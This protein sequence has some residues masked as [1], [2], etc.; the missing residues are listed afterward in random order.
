[1]KRYDTIRCKR[2]V[3][4]CPRPFQRV[5]KARLVFTNDHS[6]PRACICVALAGR[7]FCS[8]D[9]RCRGATL[10]AG[11][12][13]TA[14]PCRCS[15]RPHRLQFLVLYVDDS[16]FFAPCRIPPPQQHVDPQN[17]TVGCICALSTEAIAAG[18]FLDGIH[19]APAEVNQHDA[20]WYTLGK[21]GSHNVVIAVLPRGKYGHVNAATVAR[22]M[23]H[24]FPNAKFGLMMGI[25][26]TLRPR[27]RMSDSVMLCKASAEKPSAMVSRHE[28]G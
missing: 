6:Q 17:Y 15:P 21:I 27:S 12:T 5:G 11:L 24:T 18:A 20:N 19:D 3:R 4:R 13:T 23:L 1:M 10:V 8:L 9:A 28:R 26:G 7:P 25:E 2:K 22:D 16:S 14:P